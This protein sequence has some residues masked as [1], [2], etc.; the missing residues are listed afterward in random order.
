MLW[1]RNPCISR[2]VDRRGFLI[3]LLRIIV[4]STI[5]WLLDHSILIVSPLIFHLLI[6]GIIHIHSVQ[7]GWRRSSLRWHLGR[8]SLVCG[9]LDALIVNAL[10][11]AVSIPWPY[12][13]DSI[14]K[15]LAWNLLLM[16]PIEHTLILIVLQ[17]WNEILFLCLLW[18]GLQVR[19]IIAALFLIHLLLLVDEHL[20]IVVLGR[21]WSTVWIH[22]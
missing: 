20:Q 15:L 13:I 14:I 11:L 10:F 3:A 18:L 4:V 7:L 21:I 19:I 9:V 5:N 6:R 22:I 1:R 16:K 8:V 17:L 2:H 12:I